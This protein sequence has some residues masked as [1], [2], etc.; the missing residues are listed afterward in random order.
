MISVVDDDPSV[1]RGLKRLLRSLGYEVET[2]ESAQDFVSGEH[3]ECEC[4]I[5][6]IHMGGISGFDLYRRLMREGF[7]PPIIFITAHDDEQT[8]NKVK[9]LGAVAYLRK[10][11][12]EQLLIAAISKAL[13]RS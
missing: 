3:H 9:E 12:E 2:F 11:F 1:R 4:L 5:L 8:R 6:D 13:S 10:P 7:Q